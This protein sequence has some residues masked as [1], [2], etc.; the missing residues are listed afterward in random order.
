MDFF[1][2]YTKVK[3]ILFYFYIFFIC[4]HQL[5]SLHHWWCIISPDISP[6]HKSSDAGHHPPPTGP[7]LT[8]GWLSPKTLLSLS[9]FAHWRHP[10]TTA[11]AWTAHIHPFHLLPFSLKLSQARLSFQSRCKW[12]RPVGKKQTHRVIKSMKWA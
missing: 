10:P 4:P 5:P 12:F 2:F 7:L 6:I 1:F 8:I 9:P 3:I 11:S